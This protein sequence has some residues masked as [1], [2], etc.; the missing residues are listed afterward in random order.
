MKSKI[1]KIIT[2]VRGYKPIPK[3]LVS[4]IFFSFVTFI[5][6]IIDGKSWYRWEEVFVL[7]DIIMIR[8][9]MDNVIFSII[10]LFVYWFFYGSFSKSI[11]G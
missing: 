11:E 10:F 5:P 8:T 4:Y 9:N 6:D 1:K 2:M 3:L 7:I